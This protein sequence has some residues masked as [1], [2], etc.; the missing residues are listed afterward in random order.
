MQAKFAD[1]KAKAAANADAAAGKTIYYEVSPLRYG[2]WAAGKGT[3]MDEIGQMLGLTDIFEDVNGWG[4]VSEEEVIAR[5]PDYIVTN[6]MDLGD[7]S[8][9]VQEIEGRQGWDGISAV[10]KHEVT[11]L[12]PNI[13][14]RP[15]PRL[16]DAA[17]ALYDFVYSK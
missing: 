11:Q 5:N 10:Q 2:L 13:I 12:D 8:N 3:F 16:T 6:A 15:G 7:G 17:Q 9:P 14:T 4:Q 1:V